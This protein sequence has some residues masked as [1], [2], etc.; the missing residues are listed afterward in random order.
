MMRRLL[1][2]CIAL[3]SWATIVLGA[4]EKPQ[5]PVRVLFIG[6]SYTY[7]NNLPEMISQL[8]GGRIDAKMVARGGASLRQLWDIGDAPA[9]I[10]EGKWDYVVIQEQSLLGG[11]R[12]DGMEHVNE[13]DFFYEDVRM[14]DAEIRK[15]KAKTIL[16]LT[17]A[18]KS[19]PE[20]QAHLT[21]AYTAIAQ[22]LNLIIAPVGIAWQKVRESDPSI[23]L[24]TADGSHPNPFGSYLAAC[25]FVNTILGK[26]APANVAFKVT[27]H[28]IAAN[29][30]PDLTRVVDLVSLTPERADLLQTAADE[31]VAV[32][33]ASKPTFPQR[34][35]LPPAKK[36]VLAA[37][38]SGTWRG[39]LR[40][41]TVPVNVE[42]K[43]TTTEGNQCTGQW[44]IWTA[45]DDR[46]LRAPISSCRITDVG[47]AFI[48]P[49][50]RG[51]GPGETYWS[52]YTGDTITGWADFR[53]LGKSSRL[54]GSFELR[55]V[56][57]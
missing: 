27:G 9:A 43:L 1:I 35:P 20:Q 55:R 11:M 12:I 48:M 29:E 40:F 25:V 32:L 22:E 10:R 21:H 52:H 8:S 56:K 38:V 45:N 33:P 51:F 2:A 57:P 53:G 44:S 7:Y 19:A 4:D 36:P 34:M 24:H 13:P 46:R 16:Y 31:A 37:D 15:A 6:N 54:M 42:L 50:Y 3:A 18:R 23:V 14:Y 41:Y 17:W 30:R 47:V 49:D 39:W 28:P 26:K 5:P